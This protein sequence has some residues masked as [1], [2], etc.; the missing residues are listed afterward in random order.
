MAASKLS[1][2]WENHSESMTI[3][4]RQYFKVCF[5]C[6][7]SKVPPGANSTTFH[8]GSETCPW[9]TLWRPCI[10]VVSTHLLGP[11]RLHSKLKRLY[12]VNMH[13]TFLCYQTLSTVAFLS[14]E[15]TTWSSPTLLVMMLPSALQLRCVLI[16]TKG[17]F[18]G[19]TGAAQ[20]RNGTVLLP[21]GTFHFRIIQS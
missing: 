1:V 20:R 16:P 17:P 12:A 3:E 2:G 15:M 4:H 11:V 9:I 6:N 7:Y 18:T 14:I 5:T 8:H 13:D 19:S 21:G 10:A